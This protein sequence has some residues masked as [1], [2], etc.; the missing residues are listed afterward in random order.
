MTPQRQEFVGTGPCYTQLSPV[1]THSCAVSQP[2]LPRKLQVPALSQIL[3]QEIIKH[4]YTKHTPCQL[5]QKSQNYMQ[6][7]YPGG[8]YSDPWKRQNEDAPG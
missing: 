6:T 7:L 4:V 5:M 3:C 1:Y 8:K 2:L